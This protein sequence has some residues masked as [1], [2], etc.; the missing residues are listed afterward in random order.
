MTGLSEV[1]QVLPFSRRNFATRQAAMSLSANEIGGCFIR[2]DSGSR[3]PCE[4]ESKM[5]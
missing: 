5:R 4:G 3:Q 2:G 1:G